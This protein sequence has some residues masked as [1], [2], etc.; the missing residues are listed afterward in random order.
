MSKPPNRLA[1]Y[2]SYSYHHVLAV[3]NNTDTAEALATHTSI[4]AWDHATPD[5]TAGDN[6][7][8]PGGFYP[9]LGKYS[10]R[11]VNL[12]ASDGSK[13]NTKGR[14]CVLINGFT[15]AAFVI[16]Q[17]EW[18]CQTGG[19]AVHGDR[20]TSLAVE[21]HLNI[22]EPK[23]VVFLDQV[24][25]CCLSLGIDASQAVFVLKTFFVGYKYDS[26]TNSDQVEYISNITPLAFVAYDVTGSFTEM[27]GVYKIDFVAVTNGVTRL[28]QYSKPATSVPIGGQNKTLKDCINA[29]EKNLMSNYTNYYNCVTG[30]VKQALKDSGE[31]NPEKFTS[32][33][34]PVKYQIILDEH[35]QDSIYTVSDSPPQ[36]KDVPGCTEQGSYQYVKANMSIESAIHDIMMASP[37]V[38]ED[39]TH[40]VVDPTDPTSNNK[41]V[42]YEYKIHTTLQSKQTTDSAGH[43][44]IDYTVIYKIEKFRQ[45]Q[46]AAMD[47][48]NYQGNI[49][50]K[51]PKLKG[52]IIEFDYI[53]TGKNIDILEFDMKVNMGMAYLQTATLSDS[54]R[55][56]ID[57]NSS[58]TVVV[59][60]KAVSKAFNRAAKS[61]VFNSPVQSPILFGTEIQ[62]PSVRNQPDHAAAGNAA[63]TL[64]KHASLE[65]SEA[66]MK[67]IGNTAL[68]STLN[69][70]SHPSSL[71]STSSKTPKN[72]TPVIID[73]DVQEANFINWGYT[74]AFAKV[75]VKMPANNDDIALMSG[76]AGIDYATDFWYNGYYYVVAI[77]NMFDEGEFTQQLDMIAVPPMDI[78][79]TA[80]GSS[81]SSP[82]QSFS[83][84]VND[85]YDMKTGCL[86]QVAQLAATQTD[87]ATPTTAEHAVNE[88]KSC[89]QLQKEIDDKK[90]PGCGPDQ[91]T[92]ADT[93][94][95]KAAQ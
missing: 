86:D 10:P 49:P 92:R 66:V 61:G 42:K 75:N 59:D 11:E 9:K 41:P 78:F 62:I 14:Y 27:G 22:S 58:K 24:I 65:M 7:Q 8:N 4:N 2:R 30:T 29:L 68:L 44:G 56:A 17:A 64:T 39:M 50:I 88:T 60:P 36:T 23:G 52:N 19:E 91:K 3:C 82:P 32:M 74:P 94:A 34:R 43:V 13:L 53:Y 33:L 69:A 95:N 45:P 35:Y 67:V 89:A 80:S 46:S 84:R 21:G 47:F 6:N 26:T 15:D 48:S 12:V 79:K 38:K 51:D 1:S 28:P 83:Q 77:T 40:G 31:Q 87:K 55:S 81:P 20:S 93:S 70:T 18:M 90:K 71:T 37:Q 25:K 5:T 63:Y 73:G 85:C 57:N 16:T 72:A 54:Y 76:Q